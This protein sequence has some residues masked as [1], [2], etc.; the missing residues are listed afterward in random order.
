MAYGRNDTMKLPTD[1]T[2]HPYAGQFD[3]MAERLEERLLMDKA[4]VIRRL[5]TYEL[6]QILR[7]R[8]Q[9]ERKARA[10]SKNLLDE[11]ERSLIEEIGAILEA[12]Q[13]G[14]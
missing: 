4:A 3:L 13:S 5:P 9:D 12:S 1:S 6:M 2:G 8:L 10:E 11:I 7:I 14:L